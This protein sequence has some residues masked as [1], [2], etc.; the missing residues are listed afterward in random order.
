M[1][2]LVSMAVMTV[3]EQLS[4]CFLHLPYWTGVDVMVLGVLSFFE[5]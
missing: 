3:S 4:D 5:I 1:F 2:C